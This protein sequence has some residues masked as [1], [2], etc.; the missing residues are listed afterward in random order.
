ML[1]FDGFGSR[2][3]AEDYAKTVKEK[4]KRSAMVYDS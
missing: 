3:K 2:K 4:Y 1:I